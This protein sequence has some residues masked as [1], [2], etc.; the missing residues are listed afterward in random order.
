MHNNE[1]D[2]E[3]AND[4]IQVG[5][6]VV[7]IQNAGADAGSGASRAASGTSNVKVGEEA[8]WSIV[9]RA[10]TRGRGRP[11]KAT[12]GTQAV[13]NFT[14]KQSAETT[15][16]RRSIEALDETTA[17]PDM[18]EQVAQ[19]K[20]L[21]L[22]LIRQQKEEQ[23]RRAGLEKEEQQRRAGL[24]SK[25]DELIKYR[26]EDRKELE[27]LRT[28]L[29]ENSVRKPTYANMVQAGVQDAETAA[30]DLPSR[31]SSPRTTRIRIEDDKC[32]ITINTTRVKGETTDFT[33]VKE[34]LQRSIDSYNVLNGVKIVCLRPLPADRINVVFKSE[35]EATRAREHKQWIT[36]AMPLAKVK[37]E[38]WYPIKCDMVS[39]RAVM[40]A[41]INDG[42]TL[43]TEVCN[44]FKEDNST[45]GIDCTA[46][47]VRW[48]SKAQSQKATGS[49]VIWLKNKISA[50][51][52]LRAGQVMFGAYGAFCSRYEQ[53]PNDGL[54]YNC[55]TILH[56]NV[57][58]RKQVQWSLLND[59]ELAGFDAIAVVEPYLYRDLDTDEPR[60]ENYRQW[61]PIIPST[62]RPDGHARH[63]YRA[64]LWLNA[65]LQ[66]RAVPVDSYD[67][68]A[69]LIETASAKVL[70]IAAYDPRDMA[71]GQS[72]LTED[73]MRKIQLVGE[74]IDTIQ[75]IEGTE[76]DVILCSDFNRYDPLWGG[77]RALNDARRSREGEL[78]IDFAQEYRLHSLLP[79]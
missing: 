52:L 5:G 3:N 63:S 76:I 33:K 25:L 28:L 60:H 51:H 2:N 53:A 19:L 44:E 45:E 49:L 31:R 46:H 69:A 79:P 17:K 55:N 56:Y 43:R 37:S 57:G 24:E 12:N 15:R 6:G 1:I 40:D 39:K 21:V 65:K 36:M 74:T 32:S 66:A 20:D 72:Q 23:Q 4:T 38:E 16:K 13:F 70:V 50:E 10:A 48:L 47:K 7:G 54:C 62:Q 58:K 34:N 11:P 27:R 78:L 67:I 22:Q 26:I 18:A 8:G 77:E 64:M 61:Q 30:A 9:T 75:R 59:E 14:A 42:R 71:R 68:A 29:T 41:A 35:A 73:L